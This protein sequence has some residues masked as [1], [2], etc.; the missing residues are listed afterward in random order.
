MKHTF[1]KHALWTALVVAGAALAQDAA[2][3]G[4]DFTHGKADAQL[5]AIGGKAAASGK[6]VVV[7]APAYWQ[8]KVAGKIRAGAHGKPVA[9]RFS[10]GFYENVLV[11]TESAAA[12]GVAEKPAAKPQPR[13]A[14]KAEPKAPA[15]AEAKVAKAEPK[16]EVAAAPK[17]EPKPA[18]APVAAT[19]AP[20]PAEPPLAAAPAPMQASAP[21]Q[22]PAQPAPGPAPQPAPQA[23]NDIVAVPQVSHQVAVVP[24]PTAAINTTGAR[25]VM[26]EPASHS[27]ASARQRMIASLNDGRPAMGSLTEAQL[28]SGDQVYS[29]GDAV[30]V[31]RLEGLHRNL[32]WL[33]GPVDL[34]RVQY[35]P[36]GPGHFAVTGRI[37]PKVPAAHR[38]SSDAHR[39]VASS[40][41]PA[42]SAARAQLE[43]RYNNG[44]PIT[45]NLTPASLQPEDRLL[46]DGDAIVVAR[47]EGNSM[48]RYW[49]SGS[50]DLGQTGIQKVDA[51]VYRVI[52]N[53]LH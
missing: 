35:M 50:I 48:A 16:P 15:S 25:P 12:A 51:N 39:V 34:Q 11:R 5:A 2:I 52:G 18:P 10:N 19:P 7:T 44:L 20:T 49:L 29:D 24:I 14:A 3:S 26:S 36:Q 43:Q 6:T 9:I 32:Y 23:A 21:M 37:D 4:A 40:I 33:Q 8:A 22:A 17:Q 30:A 27:D 53:G 38:T 31:V 28:Q 1:L 45:G 13:V 41:P 42:G 46:V 47:R